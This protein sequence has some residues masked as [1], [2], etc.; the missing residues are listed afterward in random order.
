MANTGHVPDGRTPTDGGGM[1]V[2]VDVI[3][4][5]LPAGAIPPYVG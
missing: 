2:S 3:A 1:Y 4:H 5:S